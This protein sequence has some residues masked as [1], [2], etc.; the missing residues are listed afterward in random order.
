[1]NVSRRSR[2]GP[3]PADLLPP[4]QVTR[5]PGG[6]TVFGVSKSWPHEA[7]NIELE[8]IAVAAGLPERSWRAELSRL[9]GVSQTQLSNW[10][11]GTHRP[12]KGS[13]RSIAEAINEIAPQIDVT[14]LALEVAAGL[15]TTEELQSSGTVLFTPRRMPLP[16]TRLADACDQLRKEDPALLKDVLQRVDQINELI[17]LR[18]ATRAS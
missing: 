6:R 12:S 10:K 2:K 8:S 7:F 1:M 5:R 11:A 14:L 15:T 18:R 3:R 16:L 17:E 4:T 9:S 13:L